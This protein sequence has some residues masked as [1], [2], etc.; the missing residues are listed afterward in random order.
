VAFFFGKRE[1]GAHRPRLHAAP[2]WL[3][4]PDEG[5]ASFRIASSLFSVNVPI[6]VNTSRPATPATMNRF[7]R[8][9]RMNWFGRCVSALLVAGLMSPGTAV[10]DS[11]TPKAVRL[12]EIVVTATKTEKKVEDAPGSVTVITREELESKELKTA[13][14]AM[15]TLVGVFAKRTKGVMDATPSVSLRGFFGDEYT[16]VLIDGQPVNDAYTGG[17]EWSA[18]PFDNIDRIEVIRGAG[19]ALYGGNA[20]GGVINIITR[21]PEKLEFKLSA[22][23]GSNETERYRISLGHRLWDRLSFRIGYDEITTEGYPTA[24]VLRTVSAGA[25]NVSGGYPMNN[26]FGEPTKWVVGDKGDNGAR[27]RSLDGKISLDYSPTGNLSFSANAGHHA[28]FYGAPHSYMGTYG[29]SS[30]Y[31][32]VGPGLRASFRPGD[33][34]SSSGIGDNDTSIYSLSLKDKFG[35]VQFNAQV[36]TVQSDDRYTLKSGTTTQ[37]YDNAP[38]TL[39]ITDNEA[40]FAEIRTDIPVSAAHLLTVGASY[41]TDKSD[42]N[43]YTVPFYRSYDNKSNVTFYS[44]GKSK[45]WAVFVQDEW[46]VV[47]PLTLYFGARYDSWEVYNGASGVPGALLE[48]K[49]NQESNISPKVSAVWKPLSNTSVRAS[50]GKAFR[51]PTLYD[52]YRTWQSGTTL[53]K[54]NPDLKPETVWTYELGVDQYLFDG[55]TRLSLTGFRN[56]IDDLIYRMQVNPTTKMNVNAGEAQTYGVEFEASHKAADWLTL[57]GNYTWTDAKIIKSEADPASEGKKVTGIPEDMWNIGA[58]LKYEWIKFSLTGRYFSKIYADSDNG[59]TEN[60]VYGTYEPC[61]TADAKLVVTPVK[62]MD[63]SL[64]VNNIFDEKTFQYYQ[65]DGTSFFGEVTF[66]Y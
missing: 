63:V 61:F 22:G 55:R 18:L 48:H 26:E 53:N 27:R 9:E 14:E 31:A 11:K 38:G 34:V 46:K 3:H 19:S 51:A 66:K 25:G 30:T 32:I 45:D 56:D 23:Y 16:L 21:T 33:F 42:T 29:S 13:D 37:T 2:S 41:R 5:H 64:S 39:K 59:D 50:V 12:D 40:W 44:G 58:D 24:L 47:E 60:G 28:Y 20:M 65:T 54:S 6:P 52:L 43:D 17:V 35:P 7:E 49:D 57:W 62:Y 1:S 8:R 36:G 15:K 4:I 10:A